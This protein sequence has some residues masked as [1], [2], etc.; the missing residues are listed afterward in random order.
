MPLWGL[1]GT[2]VCSGMEYVKRRVYALASHECHRWR[3]RG[4]R[5]QVSGSG[6]ESGVD[7]SVL[8]VRAM[9]Q[10]PWF[11]VPHFSAHSKLAKV[12]IINSCAKSTLQ[13]SCLHLIEHSLYGQLSRFKAVGF[14]DS[15][16]RNVTEKLV[17]EWCCDDL[18]QEKENIRWP[19][20]LPHAHKM[21]HNI[22]TIDQRLNA[23]VV[24]SA[25]SKL[26]NYVAPRSL[27]SSPKLQSAT[28]MIGAHL[29]H[30]RTRLSVSYPSPADRCT[31]GR[32]R[33]ASDMLREHNVSL[34]NAPS[35]RLPVHVRDCGC[36]LILEKSKRTGG[37]CKSSSKGGSGSVG[38]CKKRRKIDQRNVCLI[39]GWGRG[40]GR[41]RKVP[42]NC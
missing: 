8:E 16:L 10:G 21:S 1:A 34:I 36:T 22:K 26:I 37:L 11:M 3:S 31:Q 9:V 40:G 12:I 18:E 30:G 7:T 39:E 2:L 23:L 28:R 5:Y 13:K 33:C 42:Q 38:V 20:V 15:V 25:P 6:F 14:S 19:V 29:R 24:F 41:F 35:G 27:R 17:K 32:Q 4:G